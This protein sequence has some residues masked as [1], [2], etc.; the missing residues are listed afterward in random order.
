[1]E[2]SVGRRC[3]ASYLYSIDGWPKWYVL[4]IFAS[5]DCELHRGSVGFSLTF[6]FPCSHSVTHGY[7][8]SSLM[9]SRP[10]QKDQPLH[11]FT[12]V[13]LSIPV[14][15]DW[16]F[17]IITWKDLTFPWGWHHTTHCPAVQRQTVTSP[18]LR[19]VYE[20]VPPGHTYSAPHNPSQEQL[21]ELL[22]SGVQDLWRLQ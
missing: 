22:M 15:K 21:C 16:S 20:G 9:S 3:P 11:T 18:D 4:M 19:G 8:I 13:L 7:E 10:L 12:H 5:L 6:L 17:T 14:G 2:S 1:M